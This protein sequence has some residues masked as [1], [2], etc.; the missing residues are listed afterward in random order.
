MSS[1][2]AS[3]KPFGLPYL[4]LADPLGPPWGPLEDPWGTHWG[5]LGDP[6]GPL[7]TTWGTSWVCIGDL[8]IR[9]G[10]PWRDLGNILA[11]TWEFF[12][13]LWAPLSDFFGA[14]C[15]SKGLSKA[16]RGAPGDTLGTSWE[17]F[18]R[19]ESVHEVI[20]CNMQKPLDLL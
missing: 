15:S 11:I 7:V 5:T 19:F 1:A 6:L 16:P 18:A 13:T 20:R 14:T 9:F 2:S 10:V 12:W 17:H 3:G 8:R 4:T